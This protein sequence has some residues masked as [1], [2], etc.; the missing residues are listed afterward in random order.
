MF[1]WDTK[2]ALPVWHIVLLFRLHSRFTYI[3]RS[4]Q[5]RFFFWLGIVCHSY[6]S[7]RQESKIGWEVDA[8]NL[9]TEDFEW[10]N[11]ICTAQ[12]VGYRVKRGCHEKKHFGGGFCTL[13]DNTLTKQFSMLMMW[14]IRDLQ[15]LS[16]SEFTVWTKAMEFKS[17]NVFLR[18]GN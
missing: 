9:S 7:W 5:G 10:C 4:T 12:T 3:C 8:A 18:K 13:I 15:L 11:Q 6:K 16:V 17:L 2:K 14:F 1:S